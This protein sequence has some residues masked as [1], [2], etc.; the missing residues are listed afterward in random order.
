LGNIV[1]KKYGERASSSTRVEADG[2]KGMRD[3]DFH[4]EA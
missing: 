2:I 3:A 4:Y 1:D